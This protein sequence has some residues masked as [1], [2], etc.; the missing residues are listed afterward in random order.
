MDTYLSQNQNALA[1]S[2]MGDVASIIGGAAAA[3]GAPGIGTALGAASIQ[4]GVNGIIQRNAAAQDAGSRYSNP[5]AFLGTALAANYNQQY[6]IVVT[7]T[8]V[9]NESL[10]HTNFGY[11]WGRIGSLSFPSSGFIQT[12]GC[13]VKTTDGSVP[14]WALDEINSNFNNGIQVHTS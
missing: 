14:K 3:V 12:E 10:V 11:Q 9:E 1:T 13:A 7:K 8:R 2:L 6:W 5:P 4:S